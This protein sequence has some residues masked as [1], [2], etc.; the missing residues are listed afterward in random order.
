VNGE[1]G[2]RGL[3][4]VEVPDVVAETGQDMHSVGAQAALRAALALH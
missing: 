4:R 2:I 1:L 3:P